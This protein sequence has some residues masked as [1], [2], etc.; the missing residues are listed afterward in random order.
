M[1]KTNLTKLIQSHNLHENI[2]IKS[3]VVQKLTWSE[4]NL[5]QL[6]QNLDHN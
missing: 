6:F 1:K 2:I 4:K 5:K 3:D